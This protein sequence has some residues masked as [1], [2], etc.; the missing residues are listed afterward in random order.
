MKIRQE[1]LSLFK[2]VQKYRAFDMKPSLFLVI[3]LVTYVAHP[4]GKGICVP[5]AKISLPF[6][7]FTVTYVNNS[8]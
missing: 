4:Y 6:I 2:L 5:K 3:L 1:N 8:T 7:F